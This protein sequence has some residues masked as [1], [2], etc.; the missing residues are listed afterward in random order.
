MG[1]KKIRPFWRVVIVV[2][3]DLI[4]VLSIGYQVTRTNAYYFRITSSALTPG[5]ILA[6]LAV[7]YLSVVAISGRWWPFKRDE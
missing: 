2:L 5:N 3:A 1:M 4:F 6:G 7:L